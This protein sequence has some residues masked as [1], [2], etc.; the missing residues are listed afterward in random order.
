MI[1]GVAL[2]DALAAHPDDLPAA[3]TAWEKRMRPLVRK[4][5][6]LA[7]LKAQ[8]FVPSNPFLAWV[9]G[10]VVAVVARRLTAAQRQ[11]A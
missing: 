4:H 9:R 10:K 2:G 5:Q 1:G 8:F 11:S 3:F 7:H 6:L